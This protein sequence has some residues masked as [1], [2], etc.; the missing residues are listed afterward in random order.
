MCLGLIVGG[1]LRR[2]IVQPNIRDLELNPRLFRG[3]LPRESEQDG[4]AAEG[5]FPRSGPGAFG[6]QVR[7]PKDSP[8]N[9]TSA[10]VSG[11]M[12]DS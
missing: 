2:G 8:S 7:Y 6:D 4:L 3:G 9:G 1:A 5:F 11:L 12:S 10:R